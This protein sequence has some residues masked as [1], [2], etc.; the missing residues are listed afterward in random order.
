MCPGQGQADGDACAG[1][2]VIRK[3]NA[4]TAIER[5]I[6][7]AALK[8]IIAIAAQQAVIAGIAVQAV[9]AVA[10]I[11]RIIAQV[12]IYIV[13]VAGA[14]QAVIEGGTK[15]LLNIEQ[16]VGAIADGVLRAGEAEI[17]CDA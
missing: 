6:A 15:N 10:T 2:A 3:V 17:D 5:V 9:I 8:R 14:G 11:N 4:R 16:G 7:R 1:E 13:A 12:G